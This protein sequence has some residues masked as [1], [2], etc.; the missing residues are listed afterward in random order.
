LAH[1]LAQALVLAAALVSSGSSPTPAR[2]LIGRAAYDGAVDGEWKGWTCVRQA[3]LDPGHA[4][5]AFRRGARQLVTLERKYPEAGPQAAFTVVAAVDFNVPRGHQLSEQGYCEVKGQ[6][7]TPLVFAV[8]KS[9]R[10]AD[11]YHPSVRAAWRIDPE[12]E[13]IVALAPAT[14]RC[15]NA[16][17]GF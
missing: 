14:V 7:A 13:R 11:E 4:T 12:G 5:Q 6:A 17:F 2:L 1:P 10:V 9:A 8:V 16:A 15:G 3:L